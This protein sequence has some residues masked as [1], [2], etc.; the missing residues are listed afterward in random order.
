LREK[1]E[2]SGQVKKYQSRLLNFIRG[3][4]T[5]E[6]D[7]KDILQEVL[8]QLAKADFLMQPIEHV[9]AWLYKVTRNKIFDW[10]KKKKIT[11]IPEYIESDDD[12]IITE[13]ISSILL[14]D[15]ATP[16]DEYLRSLVWDELEKAL[17]EIPEEQRC[18]F[19]M[20]ELGGMSF[21]EIS[22]KTGVPVNTLISRKRYA[23]LFLRERLKFL[24]SEMIN[25]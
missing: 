5:S 8:F 15:T 3:K 12:A 17:S 14:E 22:E 6:A 11:L 1:S 18:V 7:A 19:E 2:I 20:N 13:E 21:K 23:V 4:L 16:E 25:Y 24:Y 10:Y 9:E